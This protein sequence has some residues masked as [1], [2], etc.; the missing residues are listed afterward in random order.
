MRQ[1]PG[2]ASTPAPLLAT[3]RKDNNNAQ[4]ERDEAGSPAPLDDRGANP[5]RRADARRVPRFAGQ[6]PRPNYQ[7]CYL[8]A[9][10]A[11]AR[12]EKASPEEIAADLGPEYRQRALE[13]GRGLPHY[14]QLLQDLKRAIE[15]QQPG[16]RRRR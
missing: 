11:L 12:L 8:S 1:L 9:I 16:L 15:R 10:R 13:P 7:G 6:P 4:T 2:G 3:S 5:S 14:I